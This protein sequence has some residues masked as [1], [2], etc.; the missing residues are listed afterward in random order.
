[1]RQLACTRSRAW[2]VSNCIAAIKNDVVLRGVPD[3]MV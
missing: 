2:P 3:R 1:V